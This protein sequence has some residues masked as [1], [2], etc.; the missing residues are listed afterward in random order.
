MIK[1]YLKTALRNLLRDRQFTILNV[2]G[3]S[4]GL[5]CTILILLWVFN[6][7]S[8]DRWQPYANR[9][10]RITAATFAQSYPWSGAPLGA[11]IKAQIPGVEYT[12]RLKPNFQAHLFTAGTRRFEEKRVFYA[13]PDILK[14]FSFPLASGDARTVLARPDGILLTQATARKYF[15]TEDVVGQRI[16]MDSNSF[17]VTGILKDIPANSHVHFDMLLPMSFIARTDED[18]VHSHWDNLDFYTYIVFNANKD[19][20]GTS[21]ADMEKKIRA[22]NHAGEPNFDAVFGLQPLNRIHLYSKQMAYDIE[23]QGDIV[24]VRLFAIIAV[25]ILLIACVNFMNLSTARSA[26]RAKEVGIRKVIGARRG[27]LVGQFLSESML[28]TLV[29]L[30]LALGMV[31]LC[32]PAFN[33]VLG[34]SLSLD[35]TQ[36]WTSGGLLLVLLFTGLVA[37]SYPALFLSRCRPIKVLKQRVV[38]MGAG[39]SLFR[40]GLVVFQFVVSVV[41]I[42]GTS[43]VYS[44]LRYIRNRD[45]GYDKSNLLYVLFKGDMAKNSEVLGAALGKSPHLRNYT[46]ISEL[47]VDAGMGTIGVRWKNITENHIMFSVMGVDEHFI[48]VFKVKLLEGRGFSPAYGADTINYIVNEK[49]LSVMGMDPATAVGQRI[50][51]WDNWGSIVGV[52]K[53]FSFKPAQSAVAPLILRYNRGAGKEWLR[54]TAVVSTVPAGTAEAIGEL[55]TIYQRM[56]PMEAFEFGFVD[57]QLQRLYVSEERLGMLFN[58]FSVLA[59]FISCLGLWGLAAFTAEQRTKEIGIRKVLGAGV[60]GVVFMLSGG[61]VRLVLVAV[62]VATPIASYCMD[63]WLQDFA[64]RVNISAWYFVA[65]GAIA[66]VIALLTVSWQAVRAAVANPVKSLRAD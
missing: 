32:L 59:V 23:A 46:I 17:T 21:I 41:L 45:L 57:Q 4:T 60:P 55:R 15:G 66:M 8:Y 31:K 28:L 20:S 10:Y 56:S 11:A 47:P 39:T 16:G 33:A 53:D 12:A 64:Y 62:V 34:A 2:L 3:L 30:L 50:R 51:L 58:I 48:S 35:L 61:F 54:R 63:R 9:T 26:R 13:D 25:F 14:I 1:S 5:A 7:L 6:E 29:S 22:I 38:R 52:V 65:A 42:I 19:L 37:G 24:Y 44:Q 43:V 27:Q 49:A 18:I 36:G 40:N